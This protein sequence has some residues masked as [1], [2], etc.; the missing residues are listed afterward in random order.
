MSLASIAKLIKDDHKEKQKGP[1]DKFLAAL[2]KYLVE[3]R[4]LDDL[5]GQQFYAKV[6]E[7]LLEDW[8]THGELIPK[9]FHFRASSAGHCRR[10]WFY[11]RIGAKK[12][13]RRESALSRRKLDNGT[14]MHL[15]WQCYLAHMIWLGTYGVSWPGGYGGI[16]W[17]KEEKPEEFWRLFRDY[18]EME[19]FEEEGNHSGHID[20]QVEFMGM[21][22][23]VDF[24]SILHEGRSGAVGFKD[25]IQ[26]HPDYVEQLTSYSIQTGIRHNLLVYE[27]KD[28]VPVT[29][30]ILTRE[31]WKT[32]D[33]L[34]DKD[35]I[36]TYSIERDAV[37][38]EPFR[39]KVVYEYDGDL[40][41]VG[42]KQTSFLCTPG[43]RWAVKDWK[44]DRSVRIAQ[45]L[46]SNCWIP[47]HAPYSGPE[48]GGSLLTPYEAEVLG[49]VVTDGWLTDK[50][51]VEIGQVKGSGIEALRELLRQDDYI[52]REYDR[53]AKYYNP[54]SYTEY[55]FS[56]RGEL[57]ER[58]R[59]V[60][61]KKS[62]LPSI[63]TRLSAE[64]MDSLYKGMIGGDGSWAHGGHKTQF[65]QR[66]GAV[67]EAFQILCTLLGKHLN[68]NQGK[69]SSYPGTRR[70][71]RAYEPTPEYYKGE[72]WCPVTSNG[73]WVMEQDGKAIITGNSQ[74]VKA[75]LVEVTDQMA[76]DYMAEV[77]GMELLAQRYVAGDKAVLEE[78][79]FELSKCWKCHFKTQCNAD[80]RP[81]ASRNIG[82]N[83]IGGNK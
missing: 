27:S 13:T 74:E 82:P 83:A 23:N 33:Q 15:R 17:A 81:T 19:T 79:P 45:E 60:L 52:L 35:E 63:V 42:N 70:Y 20:F 58:L 31:G 12:D 72:V 36:L 32:H 7:A 69:L 25:L 18:V 41:R 66:D 59:Q 47:Y 77:D 6:I 26:P 56:L 44:G 10:N 65:C 43:H 16:E 57:R 40:L 21:V 5:E 28:C 22:L 53:P 9:G 39:K 4:A 24:K 76:E 30:R 8:G 2:D 34:S 46:N 48:V 73:T 37:E 55:R 11:A 14:F 51:E 61:P 64:S 78:L 62:V 29:A 54:Y 67:K 75:F 50:G 1:A 68:I 38:W 80:G 71:L 49:W 3:H